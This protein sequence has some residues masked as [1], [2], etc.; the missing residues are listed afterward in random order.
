MRTLKKTL[1]LLLAAMML[2]GALPAAALET[3]RDAEQNAPAPEDLLVFNLGDYNTVVVPTDITEEE[4]ETLGERVQAGEWG[5]APGT[6]FF[7]EDGSYAIPLPAG[8]ALFPYEVQFQYQGET[9]TEWFEDEADEVDVGGHTLRLNTENAQVVRITLEAGGETIT[10]RPAEKEFTTDGSPFEMGSLLPLETPNRTLYADLNN[11]LPHSLRSVSLGI[12]CTEA[13]IDLSGEDIK[14]AWVQQPGSS[15]YQNDRFEIGN[16]NDTIDLIA[17]VEE[18]AQI[19][20]D[21]EAHKTLYFELIAGDGSQLTSTNL[22]YFVQV[23]F[24]MGDLLDI[25]IFASNAVGAEPI[26]EGFYHDYF[27]QNFDYPYYGVSINGS[28][29]VDGDVY[30]KVGPNA[31]FPSPDEGKTFAYTVYEG[32]YTDYQAILDDANR[33]DITAEIWGESATGYRIDTAKASS[34]DRWLDLPKFTV[35]ATE[36]GG[37]GVGRIQ[38]LPTAVQLNSNNVYCGPD[39]SALYVTSTSGTS[40]P[41]RAANHR[42]TEWDAQHNPTYI[43]RMRSDYDVNGTY[44]FR[45]RFSDPDGKEPEHYI[46]SITANGQ[47]ITLTQDFA[48][49]HFYSAFVTNN[50]SRGVTFTVRFNGNYYPNPNGTM[51]FQV[52][53]EARPPVTPGPD[54]PY[55][56]S[57]DSRFS[58]TGAFQASNTNHLNQYIMEEAN[59]GYYKYGYQTVFLAPTPSSSAI[60]S[61]IY[62][63]FR[64]YDDNTTVYASNSGAPGQSGDLQRSGESPINVDFTDPSKP[65]QYSVYAEDEQHYRNYWVTFI[66]K[67]T[68]V[69][70]AAPKLFVN[71]ATNA[72]ETHKVN[73]DIMRLIT[74]DTAKDYHDIFF[75]NIG[76]AEMTG[77]YVDLKNAQNIALDEYWTIQNNSS[78]AAFPDD[79]N[80]ANLSY[81]ELQNV[82]KVRLVPIIPDPE[83]NPDA[84]QGGAISGTLEIGYKDGSGNI[85]ESVEIHLTGVAGDLQLAT[86]NL[87]KGVKWVPYATAIQNNVFLDPASYQFE[88][89]NGRLPNGI[90]LTEAGELYGITSEVGEFPLTVRLQ[91]TGAAATYQE[92]ASKLGLSQEELDALARRL[93]FTGTMT[94]TIQD[95]TDSNVANTPGEESYGYDL[96]TPIGTQTDTDHYEIYTYKDWEFQSAGPL[97]QFANFYLDGQLVAQAGYDARSGSTIITVYA[98]TF[99]NAGSGKHTV[100]A[101]FF[102]NSSRLSTMRTT[103]QNYYVNIGGGSGSGGTGGSGNRT[104]SKSSGSTAVRPAVTA[105]SASTPAIP[106]G[107]VSPNSVFYEDIKWVYENGLMI[108]TTSGTFSPGSPL[109]PGAIVTVLAR[110]SKADLS[111]FE[112][113]EDEE[114]PAGA[115]YAAAALWAKDSGFLPEGGSMFQDSLRR[116]QMAVV[117]VNYVRAMGVQTEAPAEPVA[118]PDADQMSPEAEAAFQVLYQLGVFQGTGN[119]S[120][121]PAGTTNRGQFA[122]LIHRTFNALPKTEGSDKT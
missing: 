30:L 66:T 4:S 54:Q 112:E 25:D 1:A 95:N 89:L 87:R 90:R 29:W 111:A 19:R 47:S 96:L 85:V 109:T 118:F 98:Q 38:V 56:P 53:A 97:N 64:T 7:A 79:F 108:G 92:A 44:D 11:M 52:K 101:E 119:G 93:S 6:D 45:L 65:V 39:T 43:F 46:S 100:A 80:T 21:Y 14:I 73:G 20:S 62:P 59:D 107:D 57:T 121:D 67:Q 34:Y 103:A 60:T 72:A 8:D 91:H 117:L 9:W 83:N 32:Y 33:K 50:Y 28:K 42:T 116:E 12:I 3:D 2:L 115:W 71:G 84:I 23:S 113:L 26:S 102:T 5:P 61:P 78:L 70:A 37:D 49:S 63:T 58:V 77:L 31:G 13:G 15:N 17:L 48:G 40:N 75:A 51:T 74:F 10:A 110:M 68:G 69:G 18:N 16:A 81:Q 27:Q 36:S 94:L 99:R 105:P 41:T 86:T 120:M 24:N 104:P 106:F 82:G 88:I 76:D 114:I 122:A 22:R 35:V 55:E